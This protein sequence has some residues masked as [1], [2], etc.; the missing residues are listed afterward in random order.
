MESEEQLISAVKGGERAALRRLYDRYA[1]CVMATGLRYVADQ[2]AVRDVVQDSFVRILTGIGHF[3]YRGEG[4]LKSWVTR[5]AANRAIDYV[6]EH[7]ALTFVSELPV[8]IAD[9]EPPDVGAIP[10]E[11]LTTLIGRLPT[12]YRLVLNL[13]VFEHLSHREIAQRLGIKEDSSA[14]QYARAKTLLGKMMKEYL[15]RQNR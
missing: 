2:E 1:S 4:S 5:V 14:S 12:G 9:D 8:D 11:V 6:R 15:K 3:E 10:P 7:Q 13:H